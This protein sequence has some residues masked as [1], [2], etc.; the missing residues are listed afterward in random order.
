MK[1][2]ILLLSC[3][4][5][6]ACSSIVSGQNQSISIDTSPKDAE[7]KLTNDKGTCFVNDT[8]S[9]VVVRRSYDPLNVV[10]NKGSLSGLTSAKSST[11]GMAFGN[12][13]FGGVIGAGVDMA[14]GSAYDYPPTIFV[15]L[16]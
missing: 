12:I 5:L 2:F 7:C 8:P 9:S 16:K 3:V 1:K 14:N 10:C 13:I 15:N 6:T 4:G 11:K